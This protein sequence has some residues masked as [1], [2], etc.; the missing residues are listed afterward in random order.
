MKNIFK[1]IL[2]STP[3]VQAILDGKKTQTRR[4]VKDE[5]LQ[6][7]ENIND[8]EFLLL[9][10]SHKIKEGHILWVRETYCAIV[11]N[12]E[13]TKYHYKTSNWAIKEALKLYWKPS[14]H[15]PKKAC[16][17]FLRVKSIRIEL[18]QNISNEDAIAEGIYKHSDGGFM[19]YLF[20]AGHVCAQHSFES[21]WLKINGSESWKKNPFVW[22]I[23]FEKIE[24][25]LD[26]I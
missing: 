9:N 8:L 24:K 16:R 13:S 23:E 5:R 11:Q 2:F 19:N 6:N 7:K 26:F 1:P 14:I 18:L 12:D 20:P 4:I 21:L 17:I 25:P 22:V 15:M 3:M 10:V